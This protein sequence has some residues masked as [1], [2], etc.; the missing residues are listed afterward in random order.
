MQFD[1]DDSCSGG[2][3]STE[4]ED[5]EI[6]DSSIKLRGIHQ[7]IKTLSERKVLTKDEV[8]ELTALT[9][10]SKIIETRIKT[11]ERVIKLVEDHRKPEP[12]LVGPEEP[13]D[14]MYANTFTHGR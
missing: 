4:K 6:L 2:Y 10:K 14:G 7:K 3:G 1:N 9:E 12:R 13:A 8:E 11:I 5:K